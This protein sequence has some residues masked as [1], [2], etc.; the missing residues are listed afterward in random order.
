MQVM[1]YCVMAG[2]TR[3][4]VIDN[5]GMITGGNSSVGGSNNGLLEGEMMMRKN[6][7]GRVPYGIGEFVSKR[8][9][10][11]EP[12]VRSAVPIACGA[13]HTAWQIVSCLFL[14]L[15]IIDIVASLYLCK[16]LPS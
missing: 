1:E 4:V 2:A 7:V 13:A 10:R 5:M 3:P 12:F 6:E 8:N 9:G 15:T 16:C 11:I 14:D